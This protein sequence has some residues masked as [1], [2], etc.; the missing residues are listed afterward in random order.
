MK[1][2]TSQKRQPSSKFFD[3]S[4][5]SRD[6]ERNT[7]IT[8]FFRVQERVQEGDLS[9]KKVFTVK[10]CANVGTKPQ[11][12]YCNNIAK[13]WFPTDHGSHTPLQDDSDEPM[14]GLVMELQTRR[15]EH[16]PREESTGKLVAQK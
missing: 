6:Y 5:G 2:E 11:L 8:R 3:G 4:V 14:M 9:I 12:Q 10:I 1:I 16:R 13:D 15:H 7:L